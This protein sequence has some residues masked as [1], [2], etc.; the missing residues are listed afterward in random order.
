MPKVFFPQLQV[1][2]EMKNKYNSATGDR[3]WTRVGGQER[4]SRGMMGMNNFPLADAIKQIKWDNVGG[5]V[6]GSN[7]YD[8]D[9]EG[10]YYGQLQEN[11]KRHLHPINGDINYRGSRGDGSRSYLCLLYTSPSPRDRQK[12]RMPSSA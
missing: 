12:S 4:N 7:P 3:Q 9:F 8:Y 2:N 6:G 10:A 1:L 5:G 11:N